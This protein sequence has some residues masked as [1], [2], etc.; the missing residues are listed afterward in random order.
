VIGSLRFL[1]EQLWPAL[2]PAALLGCVVGAASGSSRPMRKIG[3]AALIFTLLLAAA[4]AAVSLS[5]QVD[6]MPGLWLD[7][8]LLIVAAYGAGCLLG[9]VCRRITAGGA[10]PPPAAATPVTPAEPVSPATTAAP[11]APAGAAAAPDR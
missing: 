10:A 1:V 11:G 2:A 9:W 6:G 7:I 3:A 5:Q 8:G 4:G